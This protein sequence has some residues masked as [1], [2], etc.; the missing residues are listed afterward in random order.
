MW[1]QIPKLNIIVIITAFITACASGSSKIVGE[2]REPIDTDRVKLYSNPIE[3]Y[4]VIGIINA[5]SDSGWTEQESVE[6]ATEKL[7]NLAAKLGANSVLIESTEDQVTPI[8]GGY[9]PGYLYADPVIAK[10]VSG[11]AIF[12]SE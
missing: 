6:Y 2:V 4:Q 12:V 10:K 9:E 3:N 11:K 7:R 5:T 1:T 8:F